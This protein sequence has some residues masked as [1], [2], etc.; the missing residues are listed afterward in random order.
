MLLKIL[1]VPKKYDM[2]VYNKEKVLND[3]KSCPF[4][5]E[6]RKF[7]ILIHPNDELLPKCIGIT[8]LLSKVV[9]V[10]TG[11]FKKEQMTISKFTCH[12][13]GAEWE[14]EPYRDV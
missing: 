6:V 5:G 3:C 8:N 13:C 14:S 10:K 7:D 1:K 2:D 9:Y 11:L 4:C 12:T